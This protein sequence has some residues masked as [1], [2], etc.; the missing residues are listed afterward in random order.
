MEYFCATCGNK[1]ERHIKP[2]YAAKKA[3][4][5]CGRECANV[6]LNKCR[7]GK[8]IADFQP[9][10]EVRVSCGSCGWN[11]DDLNRIGEICPVCTLYKLESNGIVNR[12]KMKE[13]VAL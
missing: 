5:Y 12:Y 2:H 4:L 3:N 1:I 7:K 6:G 9:P 13:P 11:T 8:A 10:D